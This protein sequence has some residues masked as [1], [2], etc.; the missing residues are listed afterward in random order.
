[1]K[2][3]NIVI[4]SIVGYIFFTACNNSKDKMQKKIQQM[5]SMSISIPYSKM[6]CWFNDSLSSINRYEH[7]RLK[8]VHYVDSAQCT[9][10]YLQNVMQDGRLINIEK[11][12]KNNF[13]NIFIIEPSPRR[14]QYLSS[15]YKNNLL[16]QVIF[17]DT[18]HIF[19]E[20][21]KLPSETMY[22]TFLLDENNKIILVGNPLTNKKI[23]GMILA[24]IQ[25]E[26]GEKVHI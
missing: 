9:T 6:E 7:T 1:M 12:T 4:I 20:K 5:Q 16:P 26:L 23:E 21:N 11:Q 19:M 24:L 10:C 13:V 25:K 2:T 18:A 8:L 15:D 17:V 22:H 3:I 14:K